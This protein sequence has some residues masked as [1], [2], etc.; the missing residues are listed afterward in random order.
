MLILGK[1]PP[2]ITFRERPGKVDFLFFFFLKKK[3][4]SIIELIAFEE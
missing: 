1:L 3:K 2:K 4:D